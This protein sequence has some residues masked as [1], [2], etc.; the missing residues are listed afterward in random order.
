MLER[1]R[2]FEDLAPHGEVDRKHKRVWAPGRHGWVL[3]PACDSSPPNSLLC[4]L[5]SLTPP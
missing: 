2:I 5:H 4:E 1:V 3:A